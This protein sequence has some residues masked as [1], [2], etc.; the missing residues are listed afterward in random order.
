MII[1]SRKHYLARL[2]FMLYTPSFGD[3]R[4]NNEKLE[5]TRK[6]AGAP[7]ISAAAVKTVKKFKAR[8]YFPSL[9]VFFVTET[10]YNHI[11]D[12]DDG[13]DSHFLTLSI[14]MEN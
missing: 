2:C 14:S 12:G 3:S 6:E 7:L 10:C 4:E 1:F 5:F 9:M 8:C 11:F 13:I